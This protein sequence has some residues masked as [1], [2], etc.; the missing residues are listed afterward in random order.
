VTAPR[1]AATDYRWQAGSCILGYFVRVEAMGFLSVGFGF[2]L[3][4][5]GL[6]VRA[7]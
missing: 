3:S 2:D 1:T 5:L 7:L 6:K 4:M